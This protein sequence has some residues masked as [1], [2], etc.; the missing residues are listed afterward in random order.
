MSGGERVTKFQMSEL[1]M[2]HAAETPA[3]AA[4]APLNEEAWQAW[5]AKGRAAHL[6]ASEA[7]VTALLWF[8][9]AFLLAAAAFQPYLTPYESAFRLTVAAGAGLAMLALFAERQYRFAALF[10]LVAV[11]YNLLVPIV[12]ASGV[13]GRAVAVAAAAPFLVCL[14]ARSRRTR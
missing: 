10:G 4:S 13:A 1:V 14:A 9:A 5:L 8:M 3:A 11:V 2:S 6:R 7:R 12:A